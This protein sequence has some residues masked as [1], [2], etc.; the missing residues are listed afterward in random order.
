M[1]VALSVLLHQLDVCRPAA[2]F[3]RGHF[4]HLADRLVQAVGEGENMQ[5]VRVG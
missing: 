3:R 4:Q 1:L 5:Q 2:Q